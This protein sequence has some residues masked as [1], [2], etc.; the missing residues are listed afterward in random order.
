MAI[1]EVKEPFIVPEPKVGKDIDQQYVWDCLPIN[2]F[3]RKALYDFL[4]HQKEIDYALLTEQSNRPIG[5]DESKI[6]AELEDLDQ[7]TEQPNSM[8]HPDTSSASPSCP[9][10]CSNPDID[11]ERKPPLTEHSFVTLPLQSVEDSESVVQQ[12]QGK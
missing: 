9:D 8:S 12:T 2:Q 11:P 4:V 6:K 3:Q 5:L 1:Y 7:T 10:Q